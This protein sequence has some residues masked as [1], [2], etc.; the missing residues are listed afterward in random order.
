MGSSARLHVARCELAGSAELGSVRTS[1]LV[2]TLR[3]RWPTSRSASTNSVPRRWPNRSARSLRF[4]AVGRRSWRQGRSSARCLRSLSSVAI[5]PTGTPETVAAVLGVFGA[6]ALLMF[7]VLL[8]IPR[9]MGF[10]VNARAT[11]QALWDQ[12]ILQQPLVDLALA[13][14]FDERREQNAGVVSQLVSFLAWA[15]AARP[16]QTAGLATAAA[17]AS[18]P[19]PPSARHHRHP[20]RVSHPRLPLS[21][22]YP[23]RF[24]ILRRR[25][26]HA[27]A[28]DTR[29]SARK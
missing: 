10:S 11:Y 17:L 4:E 15:L 12:Q 20:H 21:P 9:E 22:V 16:L 25:G 14:A 5:T 19:R 23:R 26:I 13:D 1:E 8:L 6:G 24:S 3:P 27:Q 2:A 18:E 29:K 28:G 7:V